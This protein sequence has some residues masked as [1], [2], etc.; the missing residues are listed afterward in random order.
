MIV[1]DPAGEGNDNYEGFMIELLQ[2]ISEKAGFSYRIELVP[3]GKYGVEQG[4]SGQ[5]NGMIGQVM[6]RVIGDVFTT[7]FSHLLQMYR[8]TG[9]NAHHDACRYMLTYVHI[10]HYVRA[11]VHTHIIH[12]YI[13]S[14]EPVCP[15][16]ELIFKIIIILLIIF[17]GFSKS[18]PC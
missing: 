7:H 13:T 16:V 3:D 18:K 11:Y 9:V 17:L 10:L 12:T 8:C 4:T 2:K 15:R 6:E 5:W 14:K 1:K